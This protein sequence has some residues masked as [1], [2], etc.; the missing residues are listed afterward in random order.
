[1]APLCK[2]YQR[3]DCRNGANCRFEHPGENTG[4]NSFGANRFNVLNSSSQKSQD[5]PNPYRVTKETIQTDLANERPQW[6]LSC[7]GPGKNPPEQLFGGYPR[8][9]SLEEVMLYIR[10]SANQQQAIS[11][12]TALYNQA[13]QQIQATLSNLDGAV[14]FITTAE[15][16]HPNRIDICNQ[17]MQNGGATGVFEVKAA[18]DN[19][20]ASNTTTNQNPFSNTTQSS[21]FGNRTP[22]F[23]QPSA[24]V[25]QPNHFGNAPSSQFGQP[26]QMGGTASAFGQPSQMGASAPAFGQAS[27][28][29]QRPNPF[30]A[31][32]TTAPSAFAQVGQSAFGQPSA[33]GQKPSPFGTPSAPSSTPFGQQ[34][35][36]SLGTSPFAQAPQA[37]SSTASPF[38]QAP[39]ASNP[40]GS[41]SM[42]TSAPTPALNNPFGQP[43]HTNAGTQPN[44]PFGAP[45]PQNMGAGAPNPFGQPQAKPQPSAAASGTQAGNGPYAPGSTKQHPPAETYITKTMDGRIT[46][47]MNQPIVYKW[48]VN[49]RYQDQPPP[50]PSLDQQVPGIRKPDG[51]W[52]KILFPNGPPGYNKDTEPDAAEYDAS[53]KETYA[54]MAATGRFEGDMPEVPPMREDCTWT[55]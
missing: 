11:E 33:L 15:N 26:S 52:H 34:S 13:E 19:S 44:N 27:A 7:Y 50:N 2:F 3:G 1:M 23:G 5:A 6:I 36:T 31:A 45:T 29:G 25:Q 8:E 37:A 16:K 42:D 40:F 28:L 46:S 9:Q 14:Q 55:I 47:F 38:G 18:F 22:A 10:Q 20:L 54:R 12:V 49:D 17:S 41:S 48:R 30:G 51:G 32:S 21:P 24:P 35:S 43:S 39:A 4:S 53:V